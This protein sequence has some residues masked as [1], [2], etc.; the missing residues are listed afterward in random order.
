MAPSARRLA[1][2]GPRLAARA[3]RPAPGGGVG[4]L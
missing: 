1:P 3:W 2:G 4:R